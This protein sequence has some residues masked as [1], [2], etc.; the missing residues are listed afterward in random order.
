LASCTFKRG[1]S[2]SNAIW[3]KA[4]EAVTNPVTTPNFKNYTVN[5]LS[6]IL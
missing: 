5:I 2:S 4:V 3:K 6:G 1:V